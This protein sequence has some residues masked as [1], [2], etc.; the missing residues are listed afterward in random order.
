MAS[1]TEPRI[2]AALLAGF[3]LIAPRVVAAAPERR[4]AVLPV[5]A[6]AAL[7]GELRE[8]LTARLAAGIVDATAE[9]EATRCDNAGCWQQAAR[10]RGASHLVHTQITAVDRDYAVEAVLVDGASGREL[11]R[12]AAECEICGQ[13]ELAATIDDLAAQLSRK[14]TAGGVHLPVLIVDSTPPGA[15]VTIDGEPMGTTP[16]ELTVAAGEHDVAIRRAGFVPQLRR[17]A[18]VDGVREE[19]AIDLVAAPRE[20]VTRRRLLVP[21]ATLTAV[22]IASLGAGIGLAILDE[23]PMRSRCSGANRDIEGNCKYR[24]DTLAGGATMIGLGVATI[25]V[26]VALL[27]ID[28]RRA[29]RARTSWSP[30]ATG[31][32]LRF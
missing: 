6:G 22:G 24:Y 7:T 11:G 8:V 3:A 30:R 29:G 27:V 26:G 20:A 16:V 28:H 12:A 15:L 9:T 10:A 2:A 19:L 21:G 14:L 4:V 25:A 31:L 1:A 23:A 13:D 32:A 17:V 5:E 18:L